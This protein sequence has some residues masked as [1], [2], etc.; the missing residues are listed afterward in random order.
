VFCL[1]KTFYF[2]ET[3]Q[4]SFI[5]TDESETRSLIV[6]EKGEVKENSRLGSKNCTGPGFF[7]FGMNGFKEVCKGKRMKQR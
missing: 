7:I 1:F 3:E 5:G 2:F 6:I 4:V